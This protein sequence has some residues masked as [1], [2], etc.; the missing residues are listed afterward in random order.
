MAQH[1]FSSEI[2]EQAD[3]LFDSIIELLLE[4]GCGTGQVNARMQHDS[5]VCGLKAVDRRGN[6]YSYTRT[7]DED[8][9]EQEEA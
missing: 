3:R 1:V 8:V 2:Q 7:R 5:S 9:L 4:A 6:E